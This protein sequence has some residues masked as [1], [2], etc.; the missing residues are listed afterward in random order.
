MMMN[1]TSIIPSVYVLGYKAGRLASEIF[2]SSGGGDRV[3]GGGSG[4]G[5]AA[6]T[7]EQVWT[8]VASF[9]ALY[10]EWWLDLFANDPVHVFVETTLLISILYFLVSRS[11]DWRDLEK[12]KLT[13]AEENELLRDWKENGRAPLAPSQ[14]SLDGDYYVDQTVTVHRNNGR[15]LEVELPA[16]SSSSSSSSS[17]GGERKTVLNFAT[18]D[19][20]GMAADPSIVIEGDAS[21][22][23][24]S[25]RQPMAGNE[26]NPVKEAALRAL[27]RY[28][29][30]SCGP[31]G[32]YGTIDVH[33]HLER[34]FAEFCGTDDAILY[35]DGASTCTSTVAAFCKRG[36]LLVVDEAIYEP[37]QTGV[38]LSR[39]NVKFFKHND[40]EDLRRV[41]EKIHV[42][43]LHLARKP[44]AQ[45]R[46]IVVEGL[47]KNSGSICPLDEVVKLKHEFHYRLI[48][49]ESF[50]FGTLGKTG[51]GC[52][53]LYNKKLMHDAEIVTVS[54]ENAVGSI[55]GMTTGTEEVVEHQRLSGSGYCF[56]ASSPP[57]TAAAAI[58]AL[59]LLETKPEIL[60]RLNE[61]RTYMYQ[62]LSE[63]CKKME[64]LLRVTSDERSP[65]VMLQVTDIEETTC[66]NVGLFLAEVVRESLER[67]V[68][69]V[70]TGAS[71]DVPPGIRLT[72]SAAL[73]KTD[74]DRAVTVLGEAVD[75]VM[76]RFHD[77]DPA[78]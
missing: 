18:F 45:R 68:A 7:I 17:S 76:S 12:E 14:D 48:L 43:D 73:Y 19:F 60:Q 2:S 9:P 6:P 32:F 66:L 50:S 11:K 36:D 47:Y 57:F 30:G 41:L 62:Q 40:V 69:F 8:A 5:G 23:P 25:E 59:N 28:G 61:N 10:R 35:S 26:K 13:A 39:A 29:C 49:D 33:L 67:G 34:K 4:G 77:E 78:M 52:A 44:N 53:E 15:L 22:A 56:S 3:A 64:D 51:R 71:G 42:S 31:R 74:I 65:I 27:D 54:L 37:L 58:E 75:V 55:G 16:S 1:E 38:K 24:G 72:V 20:L 70:A 21:F 63:L 46:F